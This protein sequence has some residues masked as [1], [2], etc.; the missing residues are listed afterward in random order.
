MIKVLNVQMV[1]GC[2]NPFKVM[3]GE[4]L[5][6]ALNMN[7]NCKHEPQGSFPMKSFVHLGK[8]LMM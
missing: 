7:M 8:I 4:E 5:F 1:E 3:E 2:Q 6:D